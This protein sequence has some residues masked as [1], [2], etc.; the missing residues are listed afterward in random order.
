MLQYII[1]SMWATFWLLLW[2]RP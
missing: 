2:A 1:F